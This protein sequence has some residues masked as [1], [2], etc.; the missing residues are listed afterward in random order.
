MPGYGKGRD[1]YRMPR[2]RLEQNTHVAQTGPITSD[3]PER[4][5]AICLNLTNDALGALVN[6]ITLD[7]LDSQRQ[8]VIKTNR[9]GD[10]TSDIL[11]SEAQR[12]A[13]FEVL[14]MS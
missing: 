3:T 10:D 2:E 4:D 5:R 6:A 8:E 12:V 13:L 11:A 14:K 9:F 7:V 1:W